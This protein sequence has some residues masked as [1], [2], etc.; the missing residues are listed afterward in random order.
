MEKVGGYEQLMN[1]PFAGLMEVVKCIE[2]E[3]RERAKA[4][5]RRK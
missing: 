4:M 5:R 1:L 2:W 3:D